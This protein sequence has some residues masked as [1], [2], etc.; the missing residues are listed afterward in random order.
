MTKLNPH[1]GTDFDDFPAEDGQLEDA[2]AVAIKRVIA[3]QITEAMNTRGITK[4]VLAARMH[5]SRSHLAR[6]LDEQPSSKG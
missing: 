2:T 5:T 4:T 1:I 6:L 3:W